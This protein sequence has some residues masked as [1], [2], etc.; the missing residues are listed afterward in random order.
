MKRKMTL[1]MMAIGLAVTMAPV[2]VGAP[3]KKAAPKIDPMAALTRAAK[4]HKYVF[5]LFWKDQDKS[6]NKEAAKDDATAAMRKSL[7]S[8]MKK[9]ADRAQ[10]MEV[11]VDDDSAKAIVEKFRLEYAPFPLILAIAPNG[12]VTAGF[13]EKV[14]VKDLLDAFATPCTEKCLKAFQ[15]DKLVFVCVQNDKSVAHTEALQ[16]VRDFQK[17]ERFAKDTEIIIV[18]PSAA[19]EKELLDNL[20]VDPKT[21]DAVTIFFAPPTRRI[22]DFVGATSKDELVATLVQALSGF[23]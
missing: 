10:S 3:P 9:M 7:D 5:A 8:A 22:G 2:L 6:A 20:G 1:G 13:P 19:A 23:G 11:N 21:K 16:A 18:D 17:D 4:A 14:A 15:D 12:A